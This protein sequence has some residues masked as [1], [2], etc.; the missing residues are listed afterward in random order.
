MATDAKAAKARTLLSSVG[1][2]PTKIEDLLKDPAG[3]QNIL[4][5]GTQ[6]A[7][8]LAEKYPAE[9]KT[10]YGEMSATFPTGIGAPTDASLA[11][12]STLPDKGGYER[13]AEGLIRYNNGVFFDPNSDQVVYD[14]SN[15]EQQG[16]LAWF[17]QAQDS[18]SDKK[19]ETWRKRLNEFGHTV[20]EKGGWDKTFKDALSDFLLTKYK[21]LGKPLPTDQAGK[22]KAAWGGTL[23]P[24]VL[25][26]EVRGWYE[27]AFGDDPTDAELEFWSD[28]LE[29]SAKRIATQ[30]GLEPGQAVAVAHAR[31]QEAFRTSPDVV[32]QR[33][34]NEDLEENQTL[35][36]KFISL[37]QIA[38]M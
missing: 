9:T 18:W 19:L 29:R 28:K 5:G 4:D 22:D 12:F 20:A 11:N 8:F 36:S 27:T 2:H 3:V 35:R 1:V 23:D 17:E 10:L 24:A 25:R 13:N 33:E 16:S 31:Q 32:A 34:V 38:G 6:F 14:H 30:Q 21:N 7:E 37:A 15:P 26:N